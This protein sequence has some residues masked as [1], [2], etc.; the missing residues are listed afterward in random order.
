MQTSLAQNY[1]KLLP[2]NKC[3]TSKKCSQC[4]FGSIPKFSIP[5]SLLNPN[6]FLHYFPALQSYLPT[7]YISKTFYHTL[8]QT[9]SHF[10]STRQPKL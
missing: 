8:K 7:S 5:F 10:T 9:F 6:I 1:N 3:Q 4:N 2:K